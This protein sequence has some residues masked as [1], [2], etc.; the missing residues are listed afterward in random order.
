MRPIELIALASGS[1]L[2]TRVTYDGQRDGDDARDDHGDADQE[3]VAPG[4]GEHLGRAVNQE[5][6]HE[7]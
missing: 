6:P 2:G 7:D 3:S 5:I 1:S 4:Q